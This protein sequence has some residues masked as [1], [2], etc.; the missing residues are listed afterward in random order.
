[1]ETVIL[2]LGFGLVIGLAL[3]LTGGGG[4][5]FAV[6]LLVY[7][8]SVPPHEAVGISLAAVG[9]TA[10]WGVIQHLRGGQVEFRTGLLFA[11]TGMLGAP[12]GT[13]LNSLMPEKLLMLLFAGLMLA[14]AL[15]MWR[16][17]TASNTASETT[18]CPADATVELPNEATC[19][20][21]AQ[22]KLQLTSR[23]AV[24]LIAL[25]FATGILSGLF[26]VGGGFVIVPALVL[27]SGMPIHRA[28]AT[29][30]LVIAL[31]SASGIASNLIADRP[32]DFHIAAL[33][34]GGG[35]V[36]L[37]M[38]TQLGRRISGAALQKGFSMA[39]V[40]VAVLVVTKSMF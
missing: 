32:L 1:M 19:R 2:S 40:A 9:A 33:F 6:P 25:G 4:S 7:A 37:S 26:G 39:V 17:S 34:A 24:L 23:C 38:G 27:F 29:S 15:R 13:W 3:G 11:V 14:I 5:I 36:G 16:R 10:A 18:A 31:I 28:V 30:L 8:M 12:L 35:I 20:R 21:D 22:G